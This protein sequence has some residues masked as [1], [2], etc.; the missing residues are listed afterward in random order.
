MRFMSMLVIV[1]FLPVGGTPQRSPWWVPRV[2]Q[3][4]G[5]AGHVKGEVGREQRLPFV[6]VSPVDGFDVPAN[7]GLVLFEL[8]RTASFGRIA[9]PFPPPRFNPDPVLT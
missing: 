4:P 8:H 9:V 6:D 1:T 7:D 2:V 5:C 3:R